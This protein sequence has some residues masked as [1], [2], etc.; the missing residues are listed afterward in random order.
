MPA[1]MEEYQTLSRCQKVKNI[2]PKILPI[3]LLSVILPTADVG[4]DLVL[5]IKLYKGLA[6]CVESD[7]MRRDEKEY[8]KCRK[9]NTDE[10][11]TPEKVVNNTVCGVSQYDCVWKVWN[12]EEYW[13][14]KNE[15]GPDQYCTS[16]RVSNKKNTA[17]RLKKSSD[18]QYFCRYNE[19]WSSDWKDYRQCEAQGANKYCSDPARNHNVCDVS[20]PKT[21]SS[22]LFFFLLN[23]VMGLV[24]CIR[25]E[26]RKWVPL[27]TALF[28]F[29]P[30]YC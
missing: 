17:C 14:C 21:A 1:E 25:L 28:I 30:Q 29:Y 15:V 7:G 22:L 4:T 5:I 12:Y 13:R 23:Y 6:Y 19:I 11:C 18:S 20:H 16:E 9:T 3:I 27:I 24:T 8:Y 10:Y 2:A 26:G